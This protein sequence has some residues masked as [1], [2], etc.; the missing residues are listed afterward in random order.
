MP[1][2]SVIVCTYNREKYILDTLQAL[3]GQT[4]SE[5]QYEV[6]VIDNNSTDRTA[7]ISATFINDGPHRNFLYFRETRQGH[8]YARNRGIRESRGRYISF[9]DDDAVVKKD[10]VEQVIS[11][12]DNHPDTG[13]IGGKITPVYEEE[14]PAWMSGF[15]LPLVAG[16]DMGN[17]VREFRGA[18]YP[19]GANIAFRREIFDKYGLFDESLGRRGT[20]LEG[21]DEK[22]MIYRVREG[23]EKVM[24][25]PD[26]HVN[27]IIPAKRTNL[28]Y[29]RGQAI[30]VGSSERKRL[31]GKGMSFRAGKI[32][33]EFIKL[34]GSI[35][36]AV[37]YLITLRPE[38][39]I[40]LLRF[41]LWVIKG[42]F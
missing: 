18:S 8:T 27:H 25:V 6:L 36:L 12:F 24:Y 31:R 28:D 11:F 19:I 9:L 15:L 2:L 33:S 32:F 23:K 38:K 29:I 17:V 7:E 40:M 26:I 14:E 5:D 21:G 10:Y 16:L 1:I 13:A 4:A 20:G 41:R 22:D 34:S 3:A 35:V 30:G 42:Y 37:Y 39:G